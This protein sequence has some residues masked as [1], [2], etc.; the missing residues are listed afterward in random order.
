MAF[1]ITKAN[2]QRVPLTDQRC[3]YL[4]QRIVTQPADPKLTLQSAKVT[5]LYQP[6]TGFNLKE[7]YW[8]FQVPNLKMQKKKKP[9]NKS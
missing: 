3:L 7:L 6:E 1:K 8:D 9:F 4:R 5:G 2:I